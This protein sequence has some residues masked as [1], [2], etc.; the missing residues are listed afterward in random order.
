MIIPIISP[1]FPLDP[2]LHP[3]HSEVCSMVV[4][5]NHYSKAMQAL[6]GVYTLQQVLAW[7]YVVCTKPYTNSTL[8]Q[9]SCLKSVGVRHGVCLRTQSLAPM[10]PSRG[11]VGQHIDIIIIIIITKD[12]ATI[13]Y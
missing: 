10:L 8:L 5:T 3:L 1:L 6:V 4:C 13:N 12:T 2:A 9:S 11:R 7:L